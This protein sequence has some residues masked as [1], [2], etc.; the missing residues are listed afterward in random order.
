MQLNISTIS[1]STDI[2]EVFEWTVILFES[3]VFWKTAPLKETLDTCSWENYVSPIAVTIPCSWKN[4]YSCNTLI[5]FWK[6]GHNSSWFETDPSSTHT[7]NRKKLDFFVQF[8]YLCSGI[9]PI[10]WLYQQTDIINRCS[11]ILPIKP[12]LST[13]RSY[14]T[15]FWDITHQL[16]FVLGSYLSLNEFVNQPILLIFVLGY[17]PSV[18]RIYHTTDLLN[19]CFGILPINWLFQ[20]NDFNEVFKQT[21]NFFESLVYW[22]TAPLQEKDFI[23]QPISSI[24]VLGH[25]STD[26]MNQPTQSS[27]MLPINRSILSTN[28]SDQ[29]LF[30]DIIPIN[31]LTWSTFALGNYYPS[32]SQH[33]L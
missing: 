32:I 26:F 17:Y 12:T 20:P 11:G 25:P 19:L 9:L 29:H 31:Q 28:R 10:N 24:F 27:G 18:N 33:Q 5:T 22:K 6:D 13:Y 23:N 3:L 8:I 14:Q 4:L 2:N 1:A 21:V 30:W 16:T 15:L 7:H